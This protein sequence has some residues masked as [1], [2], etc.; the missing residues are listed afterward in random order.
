[1]SSIS[2]SENGTQHAGDRAVQLAGQVGGEGP[3]LGAIRENRKD[4]DL[5]QVLFLDLAQGL[6][7]QG[8]VLA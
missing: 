8:P 2:Y 3:R 7:P 1:M 6:A 5:E 4:E